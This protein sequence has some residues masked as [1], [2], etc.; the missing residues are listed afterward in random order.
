M[1]GHGEAGNREHGR[2]ADRAE[3]PPPGR[4]Q[5]E[6]HPELAGA[7]APGLVLLLLE[8]VRG[9]PGAHAG[10][11]QQHRQQ[12]KIGEDQHGDADARGQ[13]QFLDHR[14]V[15]H[16][17]HGEAHGVSEQRRDAG[18]EKPPER[19]ARRHLL[20]R[21]STD[22]LH[23]AVHLL[24]A[25]G[26]TDREHE[27][28]HQDRERVE[29]EAEQR[30]QAQLPHHRHQR[31]G[32][33]QRGA[34]HAARVRID[35]RGGD[36]RCAAEKHHHLEE[37][38]DQLAD[39]LGEADHV[40]PDLRRL[41]GLHRLVER[42]RELVFRP[43]LLVERLRQAVIV[44]GLAGARLLVEQR[45]EDHARL[46]VVGD[47][48]AD[49][50]GARDVLLQLL[51]ALRRAVVGVRHHRAADEALFGHL[52]PAHRRR[53]QPLHP[54]PLDPGGEDQLVGDLLQDFEILRIEDVA[55][56]VL[57]DHADRVAETA[58][59]LLVG[60]VVLDVGLAL[61][62]H[63][64][65]ARIEHELRRRDIAEHDGD[66]GADDDH[67]QPV[68]EHQPL[69]QV[70]RLRVELRELADD[71]H[72]VEAIANGS[73]GVIL[74]LVCVRRFSARRFPP[75]RRRGGRSVRAALRPRRQVPSA[76]S[77]A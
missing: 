69:E 64:L 14:D 74:P 76:A 46:E 61:R 1:G 63:L 43:D 62:N 8:A 15:D 45:Q 21:A 7:L 72:P 44:D 49:D 66:D 25:V 77:M 58:Q 65:E 47:E 17:Q 3:R 5:I 38:L 31:A 32:D 9:G 35:D 51:D 48:A 56:G 34:A 30:D 16:H 11:G 53:P 13:R 22:V 60:E 41:L 42:P 12:Q 24:R 71:R 10:I 20:V 70:A 36:Q 27:E 37:P 4:E 6:P 18:E 73:H 39:Q 67:R 28:R 59:V 33:D 54:R 50:P 2:H 40:N 75:S 29:L 57:D 52:G 23:D 55:V 26:D 68:V 19:V